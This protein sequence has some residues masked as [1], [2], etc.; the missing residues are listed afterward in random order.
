MTA[1]EAV[2]VRVVALP[3]EAHSLLIV[4]C[5][6][7]PAG[8]EHTHGSGGGYGPRLSHCRSGG[9]PYRLVPAEAP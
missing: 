5:P 2:V 7:C 3:R 8:T 9:R 4:A 6:F 1:P